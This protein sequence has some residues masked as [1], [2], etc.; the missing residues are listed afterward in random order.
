MT[1]GSK[2][3]SV[4]VFTALFVI[5]NLTLCYFGNLTR[6][7]IFNA[8]VIGIFICLFAFFQLIFCV[9]VE[10]QVPSNV[11]SKLLSFFLQIIPD[12]ASKI[13]SAVTLS[14]DEYSSRVKQMKSDNYQTVKS[15]CLLLFVIC[16][17][18]M[19]SIFLILHCILS[20]RPFA[21]ENL[22]SVGVWLVTAIIHLIL[23]YFVIQQHAYVYK[24]Q[25]FS[26]GLEVLRS[27]IMKTVLTQSSA[28]PSIISVADLEKVQSPLQRIQDAQNKIDLSID[29]V[30]GIG[31]RLRDP[32]NRYVLVLASFAVLA[33]LYA[34]FRLVKSE[35]R[36]GL[37]SF[38]LFVIIIVYYM[39]LY[40]H[41][42]DLNIK[43]SLNDPDMML[44]E[45]S[46]N[47]T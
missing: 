4:I 28:S 43:T 20:Y 46:Q 2:D 34:V 32:P 6:F 42:D 21:R 25:L 33:L 11:V 24:T 5:L 30:P 19:T 27:S 37:I 13:K 45:L 1:F 12:S 35:D 40:T 18:V 29:S 14:A 23:F 7:T 39:W 47:Q 17:F 26:Y 8:F 16:S 15:S 44:Y 38:M 9:L 31:Y 36:G 10:T 3:I 41:S 22:S